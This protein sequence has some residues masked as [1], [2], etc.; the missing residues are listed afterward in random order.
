LTNLYV[1]KTGTIGTLK[2]AV[3]KRFGIP[4]D[5]QRI[6]KE[7]FVSVWSNMPPVEVV[8]L[9]DEY[10]LKGSKI[11]EPE[12]F[13]FEYSDDPNTDTRTPGQIE[14]ERLK[15]LIEIKFNVPEKQGVEESVSVDRN[16]TLKE[17]RAKIAPIV[18]LSVEEFKIRRGNL[19]AALHELIADSDTLADCNLQSGMTLTIEKGKPLKEGEAVFN[20][21][22]FAPEKEIDYLTELFDLVIDENAL[23]GDVKR[24]LAVK[25][26]EE[27]QK[28]KDDKHTAQHQGPTSPRQAASV[29]DL[30][31]DVIPVFDPDYMRLRDLSFSSN[32]RKIGKALPNDRTLKKVLISSKRIAIQML[33]EPETVT[34]SDIVIFVQQFKPSTYE[35][36]RNREDFLVPE[37]MTLEEFK[38]G[39]GLK[40]NI[41]S[42]N[43]GVA[44]VD[45]YFTYDDFP[46][47]LEIP[48]LAWD[49]YRTLSELFIRNGCLILVRDNTEKLKELTKEEQETIEKE[50]KKRAALS[51]QTSTG[52]TASYY[53]WGSRQEKALKIQTS[54]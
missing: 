2:E 38:T 35:L 51:L 22:F 46:E 53:N 15:N 19:P 39:L 14:L 44:R 54:E 33:A 36:S 3:E 40:Y 48:K 9:L 50:N 6:L 13:Y 5:K 47:T 1:A 49:R 32:P 41:P 25:L 8:D 28:R 45:H 52:I 21:S 10:P 18:G 24:V 17:F 26:R 16:M 23:I 7:V 27:L 12:K 30:E 4:L 11:S 29:P 37:K 20:I 42:E 43:V 34:D 31:D